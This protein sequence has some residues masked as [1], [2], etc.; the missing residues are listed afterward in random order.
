MPARW[1][2]PLAASC[3]GNDVV[4]MPSTLSRPDCNSGISSGQVRCTGA[5]VIRRVMLRIKQ[6]SALSGNGFKSCTPTTETVP[7]G[8]TALSASVSEASVATASITASAPRPPVAARIA[9]TA[10][11]LIGAA[12]IRGAVQPAVHLVNSENCCSA[13]KQSATQGTQ[14][15]RAQTEHRHGSTQRNVGAL[16]RRPAGGQVVGEQQ[17]LLGGDPLGHLQ[18]LEIRGRDGEQ[19]GLR[20][21]EQAATEDLKAGVTQDRIAGGASRATAA[22][23]HR[24][25][26]HLISGLDRAYVGADVHDR[27]DCFVPQRDRVGHREVGFVEMQIGSADAGGGDFDDRSADTGHG[28]IRAG[29]DPD[30]AGPS[31]TTV[32]MAGC[33]LPDYELRCRTTNWDQSG[34]RTAAQYSLSR[35]GLTV[36]ISPSA[37]LK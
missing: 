12:P 11:A 18:Q 6:P 28:R 8:R 10:G 1:H 14:T 17:G 37:F 34:S 25:H 23:G 16:G 22:S 20:A 3:N 5:V 7:P 19:V 24:R 33:S 15:D 21:A 32:R 26:H 27:S 29:V 13:L 9:S 35:H 2:S 4:K 36:W 31:T 30:I